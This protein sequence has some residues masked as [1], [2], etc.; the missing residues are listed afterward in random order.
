MT[1]HRTG[2]EPAP[3][4]DLCLRAPAEATQLIQQIQITA[5]HIICGLVEKALFPRD[6]SGNSCCCVGFSV[7]AAIS[8]RIPVEIS[9]SGMGMDPRDAPEN[10]REGATT[11]ARILV[12]QDHG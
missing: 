1:P 5:A 7:P 10:M 3:L 12:N 2:G 4:C 8:W 9:Q 11:H 6:T